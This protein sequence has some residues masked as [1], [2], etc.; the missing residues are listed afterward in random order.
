M[1][2]EEIMTGYGF[3]LSAGCSGKASYTKNIKHDGKRAYLSLTIPEGEGFPM[4]VDE[5]VLVTVYDL[6]SGDAMGEGEAYDSL[7]AYLETIP[8]E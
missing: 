1:S 4:S 6:K 5:P 2:V 3:R 8:K 7:S